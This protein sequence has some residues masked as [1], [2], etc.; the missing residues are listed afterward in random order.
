MIELIYNEEE[1]TE[2]EET[3]VQ[4]PKNIRQIGIPD[5]RRKIFIEDYVHTFLQQYSSPLKSETEKIAVL[6]GSCEKSGGK[7]YLYIKSALAVENV[8]RK[9]GRYEFSEK[10]WSEIYRKCGDNFPEQEIVGWF[11]SRPGFP[12]EITAETEETQKTYFSG[13]DKLLM[14]MEPIEGEIGF[15]G[16]EQNRLVRQGGYCIY[17]E[18]NEPMHAYMMEKNP[19]AQEERGA[20]R[21][22]AAIANFRKLLKEKQE[23]EAKRQKAFLSYGIRAGALLIIVAGGMALAKQSGQNGTKLQTTETIVEE[24]VAEALTDGVLVEELPGNVEETN[25]VELPITENSAGEEMKAQEE[26]D[27]EPPAEETAAPAYE[28]YIV[29]KGDTLAGISRIKY[30]DDKMVGEICEMNGITDMDYIREGETI[31]LP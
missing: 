15:F 25:T 13:A 1:E 8:S 18:K 9:N 22:E 2:A 21:S 31:L 12:A 19:A 28:E 7:T 4:E 29:Q 6:L 3:P 17:Y 24:D 5:E 26:A 11:L 20:V 10:L 14:I 27:E 30:G 16:Y 23:K